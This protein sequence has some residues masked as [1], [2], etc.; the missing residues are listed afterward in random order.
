MKNQNKEES[1]DPERNREGSQRASVSYGIDKNRRKLLAVMLIG[2]GTFLVEKFLG[3]LFSVFLSDPPAKTS[4]LSDKTS[5][6]NKNNFE[7]FQVVE[8][9]NILS[10]YDNSG[11]EVFQ[12]D[13]EA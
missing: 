6:T 11:E 13:K 8:N 10:V 2:S 1:I 3:P 7:S 12:I 9:K 4:S 5:L